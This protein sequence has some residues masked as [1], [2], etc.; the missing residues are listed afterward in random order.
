[1]I[2]KLFNLIFS[3]QYGHM[4]KI[5][6]SISVFLLVY[7]PIN[8]QDNDLLNDS[9]FITVTEGDSAGKVLEFINKGADVNSKTYLNVT[10]LMYACDLEHSETVKVLVLNGAVIDIRPRNGITPLISTARNG[11]WEIGEFLIKQGANIELADW[12]GAT[13]LLHSAGLGHYNMT[14][15]LLFYGANINHQAFDGNTALHAAITEEHPNIVDLLLENNANTHLEN[16]EGRNV[17]MLAAKM[18]EDSLFFRLLDS[19]VNVNIEDITGT[20]LLDLASSSGSLKIVDTLHKMGAELNKAN[21]FQK[22]PLFYAKQSGNK[23]LVQYLKNKGAKPNYMPNFDRLILGLEFPFNSKDGY[24]LI[25]AG[26]VDSKSKI[27]ITTGF[28]FRHFPRRVLVDGSNNVKNQY[29]ESRNYSFLELSRKFRFFEL[30]EKNYGI[31]IGVKEMFTWGKYRGT[32]RSPFVR[33]ITSPKI[34][35]YRQ[36]KAFSLAVDYEYANFDVTGLSNHFININLH[37]TAFLRRYN[38]AKERIEW[39]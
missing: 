32:D 24:Y 13:S 17:L 16:S 3:W 18:G 26:L 39:L 28:A 33:Y 25:L 36:S 6:I 29:W 14:E 35:I 21:P 8:S 5:A 20:S 19:T 9:L 10:P 30:N 12:D 23:E 27:E 4:N 2:F 22:N 34:G 31:D 38:R 7:H 1:M 15:M 37:L 11:N